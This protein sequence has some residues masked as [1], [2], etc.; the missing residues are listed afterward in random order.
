MTFHP[1]LLLFSSIFGFFIQFFIFVV[2]IWLFHPKEV[3][4]F[5]TFCSKK[6]FLDALWYLNA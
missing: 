5:Y 2:D 4:N 3:L 1:I 6:F